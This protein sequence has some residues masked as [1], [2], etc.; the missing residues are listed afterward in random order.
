MYP[1]EM[2]VS[3]STSSRS[4]RKPAGGTSE[5]Q[6]FHVMQSTVRHDGAERRPQCISGELEAALLHKA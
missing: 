4:C 1:A 3:E 5:L 2:V 6:G